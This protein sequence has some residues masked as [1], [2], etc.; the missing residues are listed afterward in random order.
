MLCEF[1]GC[2]YAPS[3]HTPTPTLSPQQ[4]QV[5]QPPRWL[6]STIVALPTSNCTPRS[7]VRY[8]CIVVV[9]TIGYG[10]NNPIETDG[11]KLFTAAFALLGVS[12]VFGSLS[13]VLDVIQEKSK[14]LAAQAAKSAVAKS[15]AAP[16]ARLKTPHPEGFPEQTSIN[17]EETDTDA[18]HLPIA[19][20]PHTAAPAGK[21]GFI[22]RC[23][24][25]VLQYYRRTPFLRTLVWMIFIMGIGIVFV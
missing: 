11:G 22:A 20:T 23:V 13:I 3:A 1:A 24:N 6:V 14:Q 15:F 7:C 21:Q 4:Q 16:A 19:D 2:P 9:T 17:V 18:A 10:D 8:F 12:V 5:P 25:R